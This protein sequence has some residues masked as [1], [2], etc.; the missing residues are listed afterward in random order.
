MENFEKI[1][2]SYQQKINTFTIVE[3]SDIPNIDLYIDQVTT[4]IDNVL[5]P[6]KRSDESKIL[7]KT[8]I[9][10]YTKAKVFPP[11]IKKKYGKMHIMLLIMLFHLK[12]VLSIKDIAILFEP[13][14][15]ASSNS[16]SETEKQIEQLYQG[17]IGLQKSTIINMQLSIDASHTIHQENTLHNYS[18]DMKKIMFVLLLS[19]RANMEKQLAEHILDLTFTK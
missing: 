8:M 16:K 10:N 12:S 19:I 9:N 2:Q 4:F 18:D 15:L 17:F 6:Y 5:Q 11:P 14:F 3:I 7:T 13:I 1:V